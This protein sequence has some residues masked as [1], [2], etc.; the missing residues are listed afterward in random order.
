MSL[1]LKLIDSLSLP[2][3]NSLSELNI[4]ENSKQENVISNKEE[5]NED[6]KKQRLEDEQFMKSLFKQIK[7]KVF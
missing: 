6:D 3:Y 4:V 1:H 5:E 7:L 2:I